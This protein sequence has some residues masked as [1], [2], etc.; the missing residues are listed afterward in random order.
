MRL[1]HVAFHALAGMF[2]L[3]LVDVVSG[4]TYAALAAPKL[5]PALAPMAGA[6][7][8][9]ECGAQSA[10]KRRAM[11]SGT[12]LSSAP[13]PAFVTLQRCGRRSLQMAEAAIENPDEEIRIGGEMVRASQINVAVY[14]GGS[15]GT[16]MA[17]VL[18]RKGIKATLV[19]RRPEVV[20]AINKEHINP[21]YQSDLLLPPLVRAT[22]DPAE[23]FGNADFI[24]HAV[25]MQATRRALEDVKHLIRPDVPIVSLA[26]V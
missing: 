3:P 10:S 1:R 23:A 22:L 9:S 2:F 15:F 5:P 7:Q 26:K 12:L 16:A 18:A 4:S 6:M 20:D 8:S 17:C 25:P 14:G 19:V 13:I 11:V 24:F 21:Y